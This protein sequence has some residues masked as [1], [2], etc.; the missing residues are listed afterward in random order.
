MEMCTEMVPKDVLQAVACSAKSQDEGQVN[1]VS[2]LTGDITA[3]PTDTFETDES[4]VPK[5]DI[6]HAQATD[7]VVRRVSD[8][9][10]RSQQLTTGER[11][12]ELSETQLLLHEWDNLSLDKEGIL[13][14][15]KGTKTQIIVPKQLRSLVLKDLHE[16]MG[17]LGVDRTLDLVRE[18]FYWPHMQR[19]IEHHIG[20]ACQCI[21]QK[22]P[23]LKTR[24]PLKPIM[25]TSPFELIAID[26]LHLEKSSGGNEYILVTMDHFTRY[27]QVNA[28]RNK[29]AKTVAQKLYNDFILRLG[30]P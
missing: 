9:L 24:G 28:T 16:N 1:W 18:R 12:R 14:R 27:A 11:K 19:D 8:L 21:K 22:S 15:R 6:K 20:N 7:Q 10:Q 5:I 3:L 4:P 30:F 2:A 23:T 17:H 13:R 29:S 26:F 25:T